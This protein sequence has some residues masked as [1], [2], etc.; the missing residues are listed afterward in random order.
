MN[1]YGNGNG[2]DGSSTSEAVLNPC[3]GGDVAKIIK[4]LRNKAFTCSCKHSF[5]LKDFK[6][7][8]EGAEGFYD[9]YGK[10]WSIF[11]ACPSCKRAW[12]AYEL[13]SR[14]VL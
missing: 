8:K 10:K 2:I 4:S 9:K 11:V 5:N 7:Y 12:T 14:L 1:K 3:F 6:G 13:L